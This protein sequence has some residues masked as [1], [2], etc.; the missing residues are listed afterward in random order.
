[1]AA[2]RTRSIY[3]RRKTRNGVRVARGTAVA[4]LAAA[5]MYFFVAGG[6][7]GW[8]AERFVA[9]NMEGI[10]PQGVG[11]D[12]EVPVPPTVAAAPTPSPSPVPDVSEEILFPAMPIY[13][14]QLGA[15]SSA[16]NAHAEAQRFAARG[17]AGYLYPDGNV[18]RVLASAYRTRA[19][20]DDV[21]EQLLT[22]Q[23]VECYVLDL[24]AD[25]GDVT[26]RVTAPPERVAAIQDA[27]G[28]WRDTLG[29]LESLGARVDAAQAMPEETRKE[30]RSLAD[31]LESNRAAMADGVSVDGNPA[32]AEMDA[33]LRSTAESLSLT[34]NQMNASA[35]E[36]SSEIKYTYVHTLIRYGQA[37]R[38][39]SGT[40]GA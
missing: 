12:D 3:T 26:L 4:I 15:F 28:G 36:I 11:S 24:F 31:Q 27:L 30:L 35:M 33:L 21:R 9:P 19:E 10:P 22:M 17:A 34:A 40:E 2:R 1:M 23:G 18:S 32:I 38:A 25:A 14:I 13:A 16:D 6:L 37:L 7:G 39:I 29:R 8:I 5:T 20:A